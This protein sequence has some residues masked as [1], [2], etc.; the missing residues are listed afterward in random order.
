MAQL[1]CLTSNNFMEE[2]YKKLLAFNTGRLAEMTQLKYAAM[3]ENAFR[4]FRGT[5]HLFYERLSGISGV[6]VSPPAWLCGDLH[7]ENFGSY[8]G[9]N[10]LVYF[11][12]ND[13][14]EGILAPALWEVLRLVAS[15]FVAFETL[16]IA[17]EQGLNMATLFINSYAATLC[18]GKAV[19]IEP[20]T[21]KG[22]VKK[23]LRHAEGKK[24]GELLGKRT[25]TK[26]KKTMLS[27]K[28][29]RHF[30]VEKQLTEKLTVHISDWI[31]QSSDG[32]YNY[33]VQDV[34]FRFAGTGS[35]GV[36]RYL[37]LLK[38]T[39]F[40]ERYLLIDMKQSFPSSLS[41]F[42][43]IAQPQWENESDR[44]VAVQK[45][46]QYVCSSHLSRTVFNGESYVIGEL[47]PMEDTF[48][49][50]LVKK[51]YR[52][53]IQVIDDLAVLTASAQLRSGGMDGSANIDELKAFGGSVGDWREK[54][55]A[56]AR[57]LADANSEDYQEFMLGFRNGKYGDTKKGK[58]HEKK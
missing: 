15:I 39:N 4:F 5:C 23:F 10:K 13:F 6:P 55:I 30:K 38:S 46:L 26:G 21:A 12:M 34:V 37:F 48:D 25:Q 44:I 32:P 22:M 2:L 51:N 56:V 52:N 41:P 20:R 3:A 54:S 53:L 58:K 18:T 11:D 24:Y 27:L 14:D 28:H 29:E 47:Q 35:V 9:D 1:A 33:K 19:A 16:G 17:E 40:K 36:K 8:R 50:R 42:V 31:A 57:Q 7:L 45:R 49:Y 43:D